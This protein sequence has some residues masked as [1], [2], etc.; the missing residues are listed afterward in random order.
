ML[1]NIIEDFKTLVMQIILLVFSMSEIQTE[2][3]SKPKTH[4][5]VFQKRSDIR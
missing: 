4:K 1:L 2:K 5:H 3:M